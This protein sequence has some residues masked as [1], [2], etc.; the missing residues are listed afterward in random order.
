MD[1]ALLRAPLV[2]PTEHLRATAPV[3]LQEAERLK[4]LPPSDYWLELAR[5]LDWFTP[6]TVGLE[7]HFGDFSYFRGASMNVSVNCLDRHDPAKPALHYEREDGLSETWSYGELTDA[8]ARFAACLQDLGVVKGDRV[9]V[10]LSNTP[11]AFIA[12]QACYRIGAVYSVVFAGF[13]AAAVRDRLQDAQPKVVVCTDATLRRGKVIPL[14]ATLDEARVGI[15]SIGAVIVARRVDAGAELKADEHD[16]HAL[17]SAQTRRAAPVAMEANEPGFIIYTSGTTSKPKGLVHSGVGFLVGTYANVKWSLNLT[18]DD[19]YWCTA[20]V[21][22]LTF[23]IFALVGGLAQGATHVIF[24]GGIDTP[25]PERPYQMI[26][27]YGVTKM[28][29]APT[30]LRML[31]RAGDDKV[32]GHDLSSLHLVSLVGEPLDPE[33][34]HWTQGV[35]GAGRIFVNNTYGQTETGTAW[36]SSMVG[37]TPTR[38]G[39]CGQPLPGYRAEIRLEGGGV[40]K[41]GELGYLTL[42][43]PFPCLARTVWGDHARYEQVYL[44]DFPGSYAASDAALIDHDGHLWVTGRVDDVMNVAGHR[45]GTMELEAALITH[46]A[47]SEAAVVSRP[48][49][50]KGSVPVAFVVPRAGVVSSPALEQELS[51]AIVQGVGSIA[52][53][54]RVI[55]VPTLPRTRSGKIMRRLLRDLL[56]SGEVKG[57]LT[58]LENPDAI[59]VV[60]AAVQ[61]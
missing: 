19:V 4:A 28:F 6:P 36:A 29:T 34:W 25:T 35:L 1:D 15:D 24:E 17:L 41:A 21:G 22:W 37:L 33:T 26:T 40:A 56:E 23:P 47:V 20:D 48:D 57:D 45:I 7:G 61:S 27:K 43:E 8:T 52:R 38:P 51:D 30:A 11:E 2:T 18:A 16:F 5:E 13:S 55:I 59:E 60:R 31:R 42:T 44:S 58:S 9:G 3:S 54:G 50:I 39:A 10:Y 12:I 46:A 14:K 32:A 53:P 49:E